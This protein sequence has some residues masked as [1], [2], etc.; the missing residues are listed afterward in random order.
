MRV[1]RSRRRARDLGRGSEGARPP[2]G[3][4]WRTRPRRVRSPSASP[5]PTRANP[6]LEPCRPQAS[7][8]CR[9]GLRGRGS[10]SGSLLHEALEHLSPALDE[11]LRALG[12]TASM[13]RAFVAIDDR[14]PDH[15]LAKG[16]LRARRARRAPRPSGRPSARSP[17]R[18]GRHHCGITPRSRSQRAVRGSPAR[19]R[20]AL[21][22]PSQQG[23]RF[24]PERRARSG[25]TPQSP[26][27]R[28][29]RSP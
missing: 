2:S 24:R 29:R 12:D 25:P 3:R 7:G 28:R 11:S 16:P 18:A 9:G 17:P 10:R 1:A 20:A 8:S 23:S 15:L 19:A 6:R 21:G 22:A 5:A 13:H 14:A 27:R 26:A 4:S